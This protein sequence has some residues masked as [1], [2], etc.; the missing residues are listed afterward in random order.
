VPTR[1]AYA[2][3]KHAM[4]GFFDS[5]RIELAESG[6]DVLVVSPGFVASGIRSRALGPDGKPLR[7]SPRDERSDTMSLEECTSI[8]VR[9]IEKRKREVVMTPK[10]RL[11]LFVKLVAPQIVDRMAMRAVREK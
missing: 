3:S 4:Q 10:A 6:V 1:T 7:A 11:G 5:L 8:L 2:A 9:A